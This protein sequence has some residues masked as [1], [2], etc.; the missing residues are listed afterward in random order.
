MHLKLGSPQE[1]KVSIYHLKYFLVL[2]ISI[3]YR[4][5][6]HYK[7]PIHA[8]EFRENTYNDQSSAKSVNRTVT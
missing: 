5:F 8:H 6:T 1:K 4:F 7:A 3:S 2:F